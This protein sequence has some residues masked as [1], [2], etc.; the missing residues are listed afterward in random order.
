MNGPKHYA[1]GERWIRIAEEH[2]HQTGREP[3]RAEKANSAALIAAAHFSAAQVAATVDLAHDTSPHE[4]GTGLN[5]DEW[6][7]AI[8]S[9]T[10]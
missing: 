7:D 3:N 4:I 6:T 2:H 8:A 5:A 10:A 9:E 1:E